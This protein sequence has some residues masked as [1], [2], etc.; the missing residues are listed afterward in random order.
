M[1]NLSSIGSPQVSS[2]SW[3]SFLSAALL[4]AVRISGIFI[5]APVFSSVAIPVR[6]KAGFV[7]VLTVLVAPV[8]A[9]LPGAQPELGLLPVLGELGLAL[10]FGL[11][12]SLLNEM[13]LLTGQLIGTQ[14]SFSL[15]NLLDPN[16]QIQTPLFGQMFGLLNVTVLVSAGLHRTMLA[17]LM[18]SFAFV[19]VGTALLAPRLGNAILYA[20]GGIFLASLQLAAPLMA[21][22]MLVEVAIALMARISPQLPVL[23]L[24]VPAKTIVG[25]VVLIGSLALWPAFFEARFCGLLKMADTLLRQCGRQG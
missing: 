10:L 16:S 24:T 14:F 13:A 6:I 9:T 23:A 11:S 21:A 19:P 17:S 12:L 7:L 25:Y 2:V 3:I 22:T 5:F 4:V 8:A 18:R 1:L 15:V 20:F